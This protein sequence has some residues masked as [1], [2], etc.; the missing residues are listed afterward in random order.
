M[1][2]PAVFKVEAKC[3]NFILIQNIN[4]NYQLNDEL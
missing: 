1:T 4:K 2:K 3:K